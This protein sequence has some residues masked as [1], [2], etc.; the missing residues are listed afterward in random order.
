MSRNGKVYVSHAPEDVARCTPL[1]QAL[2]ERNINCWFETK[3][4]ET[5]QQLSE[6]TLRAVTDR[7][8]FLRVCTPAAQRSAQMKLEAESFRRLQ[9]ADRERGN[10]DQRLFVNVILDPAYPRGSEDVSDLTIDATNKPLSAW[11]VAMYREAGKVK[12]TRE[13]SQRTLAILVTLVVALVLIGAV[14]GFIV[15]ATGGLPR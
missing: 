15:V 13:M 12:A 8:V 2:K 10:A 4:Y 1:V 3:Q 9:A 5:G 6:R 11:I 14:F 7:D